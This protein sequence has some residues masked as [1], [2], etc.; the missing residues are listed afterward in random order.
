MSYV[1]NYT[2]Q[3]MTRIGNDSC[4]IDQRTIQDTNIGNYTLTNFASDCPM[5]KTIE[6]ATNQPS[7]FYTGSQ[8]V[9]INGCNIDYNSKLTIADLSKTKCK[10]S[11]FQRPFSTVPYLGR[12][13]SNC[14]LESQVQQGDMMT[15]R[16]SV[17][18]LSEQSY[19]P[20]SNYPLIPS[21]KSTI[22]NPANLVEG[23]ASEGWIRGGL[24][25]RDLIRDQD[26][27]QQSN[28]Q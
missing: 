21:I 23:I 6:F 5:S 2:F 8:Q 24:P 27:Y 15:N 1:S 17:N 12:G 7:V 3:N 20:Y 28:K 18:T 16:K 14:I 22:T 11:L 13:P 26:Y 4:Y 25:S 19:T 10:I 9:G